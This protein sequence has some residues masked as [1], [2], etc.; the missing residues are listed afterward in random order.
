MFRLERGATGF[1]GHEPE[2][3]AVDI[4]LFKTGCYTASRAANGVV[5]QFAEREYP[6]SF[7]FAVIATH[8]DRLRVLCHATH[9]WVAF[10][11]DGTGSWADPGVF[12]DP[13]PWT[14]VLADLGFTLLSRELLNTP[15]DET[16]T[17]ALAKAEWSQI[18]YWCP[19]NVGRT[20]FNGWD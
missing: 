1:G 9:P 2:R 19:P 8:A 4:R 17:T 7:H 3:S 14:G 11:E 6:G 12:I 13:P 5:E 20:L 18:R 15:L 10:A 16:D